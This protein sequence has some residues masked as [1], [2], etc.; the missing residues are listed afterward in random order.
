MLQRGIIFLCL[1]TIATTA[2]QAQRSV[3]YTITCLKEN[4]Y[5][6]KT[7]IYEPVGTIRWYRGVFVEGDGDIARVRV[8]NRAQCT[9]S[10]L[11]ILAAFWPSIITAMNRRHPPAICTPGCGG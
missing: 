7:I 2:A 9:N 6:E 4:V 10:V 1:L 5:C 3:G 8:S 11:T